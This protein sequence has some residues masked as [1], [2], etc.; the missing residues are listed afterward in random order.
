MKSITIIGINYSPEST[1]IGL[2]TSQLSEYFVSKG[3]AVTIITGFPYYPSWKIQDTYKNKPRFVKEVINNVTVLRYK[4]YV[5]ENPTFFKRI[6]HLI[7]F[8]LGSCIN[9]FKI[10]KTDVVLCIVPFTST[11]FLGKIL[12]VLKKA[13]LWVHIQDFEFD[14]AIDTNLIK[15]SSLFL[16]VLLKIESTLLKN[17][18]FSSTISKSMLEKLTNKNNN[19]YSKLLPNWVAIDDISPEKSKTH[20]HLNSKKFKILYSG[21]IGEKQDWNFFIAF[22]NEIKKLENIELIV[23]G[24][25]GKKKWLLEETKNITCIK[26]H[27]PVPYNELSDLLCSAD[28]HIL[29]QKEEVKDTVMPSKIL[30]MMAS[31]KPLLITGNKASEVASIINESG[32]GKYF[33]SEDLTEMLAY[34]EKLQGNTKLIEEY[35]VSGRSYVSNNYEKSNVLKE[36]YNEFLKLVSQD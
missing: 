4:Q 18:N 3:I 32:S 12:S 2:Y 11:V 20:S 29:F 14:A 16:K 27:Y 23:V 17:A 24:D 36:F 28:L 33:K 25:G 30:A 31:K 7:D 22:A 1:A 13:K 6:L 34:I 15:E 10:Q 9:L 8:T 26:H 35:G 21:N 19:N 5:P